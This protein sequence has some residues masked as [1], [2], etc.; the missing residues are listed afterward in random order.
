MCEPISNAGLWTGFWALLR[1]RCPRCRIG[2]MFRARFVMNDPC[3]ECGLIFQREEGYFLGA[4]YASYILSIALIVP[5]FLLVLLLWPGVHILLAATVA[6][7]AYLPFI[8]AVFRYSRALWIYFDRATCPSDA[9]A[10][11]YEKIRQQEIAE[12][13]N[14]TENS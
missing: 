12:R 9:S 2:A 6:L 10:Q 11:A 3:P 14:R 7:I 4:M 8:P 5:L 1:L 13:R